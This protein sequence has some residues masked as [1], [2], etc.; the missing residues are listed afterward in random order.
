MSTPAPLFNPVMLACQSQTDGV[1][2]VRHF[3][4]VIVSLLLHN[5]TV[6]YLAW[7]LH[8]IKLWPDTPSSRVAILQHNQP[9]KGKCAYNQIAL[10][11]PPEEIITILPQC[12]SP[13]AALKSLPRANL[14]VM[15]SSGRPIHHLTICGSQM[16]IFRLLEINHAFHNGTSFHILLCDL[17]HAYRSHLYGPGPP[18]SSYIK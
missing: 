16:Q 10:R 11:S 18:F 1:Y 9:D 3:L 5:W 2:R 17:I 8:G 12:S 14:S 7:Q 4:E 6:C 13:L 15:A